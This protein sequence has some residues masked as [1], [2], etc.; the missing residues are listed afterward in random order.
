[1]NRKLLIAIAIVCYVMAC[2]AIILI[3]IS[4]AETSFP[5]P[6]YDAS[7][8]PENYYVGVP[9]TAHTTVDLFRSLSGIEYPHEY[10]AGVF[11]CSESAAFVECY[12]ENL[13]YDAVIVCGANSQ[14]Q[15]HAWVDVRNLTLNNRTVTMHLERCGDVTFFSVPSVYYKEDQ[16]CYQDVFAACEASRSCNDWDWWNSFPQD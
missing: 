12:L 5:L 1:M 11:D 16:T 14:K 15:Y 8:I 2:P 4:N 7:E 6:T 10:E 13:G 3:A 9:D